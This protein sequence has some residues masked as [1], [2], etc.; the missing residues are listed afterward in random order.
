MADFSEQI[1]KI[2][3]N[4][5]C[6]EVNTILKCSMTGRK[7]PEPPHAL[8]DIAEC[9]E[10]KLIEL[11]LDVSEVSDGLPYYERF[12][13]I[14]K[15]AGEAIRKDKSDKVLAQED[16]IILLRIKRNSDQIKGVFEALA[17]REREKDFKKY[18]FSRANDEESQA[19]SATLLPTER[20][21]T[22]NFASD[23][24][25][26]IRKVWELGVEE[27]VMQTVIQLDGDVVTRIQPQRGDEKH[28]ILH[29]IHNQSVT[30]AIQFWNQ[31]IGIVVGSL[32][33]LIKGAFGAG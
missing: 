4:L 20:A 2:A 25:V 15:T 11:R 6:I 1:S 23:E 32:K 9:Y 26:V 19:T 30:T 33:G 3:E 18:Q 12:D 24:L 14:R 5:L 10:G 28:K 13:K 29:A 31:L 7:M 21:P 8:I 16:V 22:L 17:Q 27:I